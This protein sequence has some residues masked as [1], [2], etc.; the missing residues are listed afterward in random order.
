MQEFQF[1]QPVVGEEHGVECVMYFC[2]LRAAH[3]LLFCLLS[4][5]CTC[6]KVHMPFER[7]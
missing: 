7:I 4:F 3:L 2:A 6:G 5:F 1:L